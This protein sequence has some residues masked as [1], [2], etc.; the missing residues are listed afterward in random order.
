[1]LAHQGYTAINRLGVHLDRLHSLQPI[2]G[3]GAALASTAA[4]M[5]HPR[6][7][8]HPANITR[9]K[10]HL[11]SVQLMAAQVLATEPPVQEQPPTAVYSVTCQLALYLT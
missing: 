9:F 11:V 3:T 4:R 2:I 5:P 1:M 10:S 7:H 8:L 6:G